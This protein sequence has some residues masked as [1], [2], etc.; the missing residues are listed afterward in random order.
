MAKRIFDKI[1]LLLIQNKF[2]NSSNNL[3]QPFSYNLKSTYI[4]Q[5]KV[6]SYKSFSTIFVSIINNVRNVSHLR[7]Y[8]DSSISFNNN[9]NVSYDELQQLL[10][11][12]NKGKQKNVCIIDVR[13]PFE[14]IG[15]HIPYA[16]NIPLN[17]FEEAL[18]LSDD[19][20][21][22]IYGSPKFNKDDQV[23]LYC[24]AGQ[25]SMVAAAIAKHHGFIGARNYPG[26]WLEFSEKSKTN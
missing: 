5:N 14:L 20:F 3:L 19:D 15:G 23:I 21:N 6:L 17:E 18:S 8:S 25:R 9:N 2:R 26:S 10:N 13:E 16:I 1:P 4:F 22:K 24:K 11:E 12:K 7:Y